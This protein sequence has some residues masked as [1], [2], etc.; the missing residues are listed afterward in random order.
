MMCLKCPYCFARNDCGDEQCQFDEMD[1]CP[2]CW[3]PNES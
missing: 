3:N 2:E 1:V